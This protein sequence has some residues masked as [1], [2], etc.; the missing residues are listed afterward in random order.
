MSSSLLPGDEVSGA[1]TV[2]GLKDGL[3]YARSSSG[4]ITT[5]SPTTPVLVRH[6]FTAHPHSTFVLKGA[7][8][9]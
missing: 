2:V 7:S 5:V 9:Y 3:V 6:V 8:M 1:L 4:S